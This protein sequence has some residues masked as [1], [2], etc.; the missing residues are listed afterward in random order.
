M[1][2]SSSMVFKFKGFYDNSTSHTPIKILKPRL[3][4][5]KNLILA[6]LRGIMNDILNLPDKWIWTSDPGSLVG[7]EFLAWSSETSA[8]LI[9][10][11][12]STLM[13]SMIPKALT[14]ANF[15]GG[16]ASSDAATA[17]SVWILAPPP[18]ACGRL[19]SLGFDSLVFIL[20]VWL[21]L[22]VAFAIVVVVVVDKKP[23]R[24]HTT[25]R[26]RIASCRG[27]LMYL[28]LSFVWSRKQRV[29]TRRVV[30][31]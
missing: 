9:R 24:N 8:R 7:V 3:Q 16:K 19:F 2:Q 25:L 6:K 31:G 13:I 30:V 22:V 5:S 23:G 14:T 21:L 11:K 17:S 10:A 28:F 12:M 15:R 29:Y 1:V 26:C 18:T 27:H 20:L 4:S